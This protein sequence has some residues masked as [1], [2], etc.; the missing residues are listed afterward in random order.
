[1]KTSASL[2]LLA[3]AALLLTAPLTACNTGT[4]AGDTNVERGS[5]KDKDPA[6]ALTQGQVNGD[7][8]TAG[9]KTENENA[10]TGREVYEDAANRKDR[11]NDGIA[12]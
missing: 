7:S 10:P 6:A 12:D 8:T 11:N 3:A 1:M 9:I 5:Q 2:R 4:E